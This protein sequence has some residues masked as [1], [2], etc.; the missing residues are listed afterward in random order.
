[1]N[2]EEF[3]I[4]N[5]SKDI[6]DDFSKTE[7]KAK[8]QKNRKIPVI[9]ISGFLGSGKTTLLN[10][11]LK[12]SPNL[13]IGAIVNDFGIINIDS[14]LISNGIKEQKIELSNG[15]ICCMIGDNGLSEPLSK[16]AN[17]DSLLDA[18]IIEAS[19]IAEPYD[20][21]K[22]LQYSGNQYSYFGGNIYLIDAQNFENSTSDFPTHFK[23]CIKASDI[24]ILNKT[25]L[26]SEVKIQEIHK[27]IRKSNPNSPIIE[28]Q[29]AKINPD[30]IFSWQKSKQE[31]NE[32]IKEHIHDHKDHIHNQFQSLAFETEKPLNPQKFLSFLDNLPKN[33]FRM[34]GICYFG[35]KGYEQKFIVQ[36]VGKTVEIL[37]EEWKN[38]EPK[39]ELV[40]IGTDLNQDKIYKNLNAI[41]DKNPEDITP[42]N[43]MNFER[44]FLTN[45]IKT[46]R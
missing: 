37:A 2:N 12:S 5:F 31:N 16:L 18:I 34:K 46:D 32:K 7:I 1:M 33:L 28:S 22:T 19:G 21:L 35:M 36:I 14:K 6:F 8:K 39:T 23:K 9:M 27:F 45:Q 15:C 29:N 13:K 38:Q 44:F 17:K 10:H 25:D 30:L 4:S 24:I 3:D 26:V 11:I 43:M 41:I 20:L 42:E 40:L